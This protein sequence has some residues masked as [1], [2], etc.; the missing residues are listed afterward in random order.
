ML[1][2]D[3]SSY[4]KSGAKSRGFRKVRGLINGTYVFELFVLCENRI[5]PSL[6]IRLFMYLIWGI[7]LTISISI[8]ILL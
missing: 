7:W 8:I 4:L 6:M 3:I 1:I 2:V 5:V